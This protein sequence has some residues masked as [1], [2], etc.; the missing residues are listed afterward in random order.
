VDL[1]DGYDLTTRAL[2]N[3]GLG[4]GVD[5]AVDA[6]V[7][8]LGEDASMLSL[9]KSTSAVDNGYTAGYLQ[10]RGGRLLKPGMYCGSAGMQPDS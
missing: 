10:S 3:D 4:Y 9:I 1:L 6:D 8:A 7:L 2:V 5:E